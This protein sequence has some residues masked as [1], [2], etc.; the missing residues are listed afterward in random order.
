MG[1]NIFFYQ[2]QEQQVE[3][4]REREKNLTGLEN[5]CSSNDLEKHERPGKS[6]FVSPMICIKIQKT[7]VV[8]HETHHSRSSRSLCA[9]TYRR[10]KIRKKSA[11]H[12]ACEEK[13]TKRR[14]KQERKDEKNKKTKKQKKINLFEKLV[15]SNRYE[16]IQSSA[17]SRFLPR[18]RF[19]DLEHF[20]KLS[21]ERLRR[22]VT[23]TWSAL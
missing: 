12:K 2:G 3:K 10:T 15:S 14:E 22:E 11:E 13:Q 23:K 4:K 9:C 19:H 8:M 21:E 17:I 16:S 18:L 1:K 7:S 5:V 6:S 20:G